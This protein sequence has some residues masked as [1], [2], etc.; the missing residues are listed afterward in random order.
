M[1]RNE[2]SAWD[3]IERPTHPSEEMIRR[4]EPEHG[5]DFFRGKDFQGRHIFM[6]RAPKPEG[7]APEIQKLA[8]IDTTFER[9]DNRTWQLKL[10]LRNA[11]HADIFGYLCA[12]L[13]EYTRGIEKKDADQAIPVVLMQ[14]GRWQGMLRRGRL[15]LLS[16]NQQIGLFGEL[17]F[18]RDIILKRFPVDLAV[19]SW[20][21]PYGDEQDFSI[22][23]TLVEVKTQRDTSDHN[24]G[25]S[26]LNQL[27]ISS[28]PIFL[29]HQTIGINDEPTTGRSIRELVLQMTSEIKNISPSSSDT[30][31]AALHEVGYSDREE[32]TAPL[33]SLQ[34]R[35]VYQVT[36][37]FPRITPNMLHPGIVSGQYTIAISAVAPYEIEDTKIWEN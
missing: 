30:F 21:G 14:L 6:F 27:D 13:I 16:E 9:F 34:S 29:C 33:R 7:K 20:R 22:N 31:L 17:L 25:I 12:N 28:G 36:D 18:L 19:Q 24:L 32:Y 11:D 5:L 1:P 37:A 4:A 8:D 23:N 35:A 2:S 10:I 15:D 3:I 26:S